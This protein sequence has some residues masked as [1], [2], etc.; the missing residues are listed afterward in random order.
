M[1]RA[2]IAFFVIAVVAFLLGLGGVA[3]ISMDIGRT[4]LIVFLV[5][6]VLSFLYSAVT[7]KGP[8]NIV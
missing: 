1:V 5:L 8:R 2:A 6:S 3:G 4:L 7:G